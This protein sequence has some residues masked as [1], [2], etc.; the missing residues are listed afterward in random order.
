MYICVRY[1]NINIYVEGVEFFIIMF[2]NITMVSRYKFI[3]S[4]YLLYCQ[5][6]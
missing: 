5:P 4:K 2:I 3:A 6:S 1:V